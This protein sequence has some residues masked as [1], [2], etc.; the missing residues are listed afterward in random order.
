MLGA[1][2]TRLTVTELATSSHGWRD[3]TMFVAGGG[4]LPGQTV[5]LRHDGRGYPDN[6]T[7]PPAER[8]DGPKGKVLIAADPLPG[9]R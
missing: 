7:V 8:Y 5:R 4:I 1:S 3:P 9:D 2:V 6:P